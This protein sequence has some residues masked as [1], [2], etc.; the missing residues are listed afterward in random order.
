MST[1]TLQEPLASLLKGATFAETADIVGPTMLRV[2]FGSAFVLVGTAG[3]ALIAVA[4]MFR[5]APPTQVSEFWHKLLQ[6]NAEMGG[7][8]AFAVQADGWI[9]L[10]TGRPLRGIDAGEFSALVTAV[11]RFADDYDDKLDLEFF[12]GNGRIAPAAE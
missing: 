6:L 5:N 4:P 9:I 3:T 10:H 1:V 12:G 8:A 2:Q 11:G 7:V